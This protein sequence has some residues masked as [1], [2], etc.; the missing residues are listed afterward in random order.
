MQPSKNTT[1]ELILNSKLRDPAMRNQGRCT[2][3]EAKKFKSLNVMHIIFG[4]GESNPVWGLLHLPSPNAD[5]PMCPTPHPSPPNARGVQHHAR[6]IAHVHLRA[7]QT[8]KPKRPWWNPTPRLSCSVRSEL[9][10]PATRIHTCACAKKKKLPTYSDAG[11]RTPFSGLMHPTPAV[12]N[13]TPESF[14]GFRPTLSISSSCPSAQRPD[15][16]GW[17][18][19]YAFGRGESNPVC[20]P[21]PLLIKYR[22]PVVSNTTPDLSGPFRTPRF[23]DE[24]PAQLSS[25]TCA[26]AKKKKTS[27]SGQHIRT[28]GIEPRFRPYLRACSACSCQRMPAVSNTT[29]DYLERT[30]ASQTGLF[31]VKSPTFVLSK[32]GES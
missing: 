14:G 13:T 31:S 29:P 18:I 23:S 24:N 25:A 30:E 12:S 22:T 7:G 15:Q 4:R 21:N 32:S 28:R 10:D 2:C 19:H 26:C 11:D 6:V 8:K 1:P 27:L 5:R 3:M 17:R 20:G 16:K 9:R